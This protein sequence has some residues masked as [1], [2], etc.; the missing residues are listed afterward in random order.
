[1]RKGDYIVIKQRIKKKFSSFLSNQ[2]L[3]SHD[4]T[5]ISINIGISTTNK[6]YVYMK[7][8]FRS[9]QPSLSS[10]LGL[11][12]DLKSSFQSSLWAQTSLV[13]PAVNVFWDICYLSAMF[14]VP[15]RADNAGRHLITI[16]VAEILKYL[17]RS[18]HQRL[19]TNFH[20]SHTIIN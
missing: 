2:V 13:Q 3:T 9:H 1:M 20:P 7:T 14:A 17:S 11:K 12:C 8:N 18:H 6:I 19:F 16:V 15:P 5:L 10:I 4:P